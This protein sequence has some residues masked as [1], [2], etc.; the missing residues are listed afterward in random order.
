VHCEIEVLRPPARLL[1][2]LTVG[3]ALSGIPARSQSSPDGSGEKDISIQRLLQR[4]DE[5]EASQK[6]LREKLDKLTGSS[7][8]APSAAVVEAA[9]SAA[10]ADTASGSE[11]SEH[12]HALGPVKFQG[13]SDFDYGR[14][15]FEKLPPGG[16]VGSTNSFNIGDFDLFTNTRISDHWSL[17]GELLV[18]SDFT[19]EFG[20]EIDRLMVTYR[21]NDYLKVS[22]GKFNTALGY[23]PNAFHRAH[24]FQT[25]ISRPIMFA[26]ED[27][28]GILPV[29]SVGATATGK[30]PSGA[31]GLHWVAEVANG[32]SNQTFEV[33][34]QNFVDENN[35]KAMNFALYARPDWLAGLQTGVSFYHD[36][37]HPVETPTIQEGIYTAHIAYLGSKLE[38]LNEAALIRHAVRG[39]EV[40][41]SLTSYTQISRAFGKTRPYFRYDYQNVPDQ[42][43]IFGQ[44]GRRNGPSIGVTQ[45]LNNY[46]LFKVQY[47]RL[48]ERHEA[49]TNDLSAQLAL[50]F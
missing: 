17:L 8:V 25:G 29:H 50:A 4:I 22:F 5:L 18:S 46:L 19:N 12:V 41:R 2:A 27:N 39:E 31:L 6:Q 44:L 28:G 13:F 35:G 30:I 23:Y 9:P 43:P 20:A 45:H 32:R 21:A 26:D 47:G 16:L 3:V 36:V 7:E 37:L 38:W 24:Y 42:E 49:P 15:W 14:A 33:P 1:L 10:S 48:S 11:E 40:F 34:I